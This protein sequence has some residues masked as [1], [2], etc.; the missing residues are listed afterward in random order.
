MSSV[1][2]RTT[3]ARPA[4]R[5]RRSTASVVQ[6]LVIALG[7]VMMVGGFALIAVDYRPYKI[8]TASM[9]PTLAIGDTVLARKADGGSVGRGDIVVFQDDTWGA[10]SMVKRVVAVGGDTVAGDERGRL[11]VNGTP[12]REP[13]LEDKPI[14]SVA[15]SVAV[16]EGRLF[17]LGDDRTNSLDSRSHLELAAG[18]VPATG[19]QARVEAIVLPFSRAGTQSRTTAFDGLG[20]EPAHQPGPLVPAAWAAAGGAATVVLASAAGGAVQLVRRLRG[21]RA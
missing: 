1:A 6:G 16:P 8:P 5:T 20:G 4:G 19:V 2:E 18:T 14:L 12:V 13:Y 15:F 17:L 7:F 10:E 3:P 21:R 9:T 11:T